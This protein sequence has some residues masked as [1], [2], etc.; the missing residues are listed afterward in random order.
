VVAWVSVA[1]PEPVTVR[2]RLTVWRPT[3]LSPQYVLDTEVEV[4]VPVATLSIFQ[5]YV[6]GDPQL[7]VEVQVRVLHV[8]FQIVVMVGP[9]MV[10][11]QAA[12]A[13]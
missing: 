12:S 4:L 3:V 10:V 2:E 1:L 13:V 8:E 11:V 9:L 6:T 5:A 7:T